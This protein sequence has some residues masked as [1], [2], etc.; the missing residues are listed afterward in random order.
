VSVYGCCALFARSRLRVSWPHQHVL[1]WGGLRGALAMALTLGLPP[2]LP[3]REAITAVV[4]AVVGFS[5]I[6]QG[7]TM[8]PLLWR[9]GELPAAPR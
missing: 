9:L 4:F 8:T 3:G 1:V 2:E 5:V 7:M 6:V